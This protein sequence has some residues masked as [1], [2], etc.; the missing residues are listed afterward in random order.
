MKQLP[1]KTPAKL[2]ELLEIPEQNEYVAICYQGTNA[3]WDTGWGLRSFSYFGLYEPMI[4]HLAIAF[5]LDN[6]IDLGS[7]D[8]EPTHVL[9]FEKEG[10][11]FIAE[12]VGIERF[13]KDNN[14]AP[15]PLD[16]AVDLAKWY[17]KIDKNPANFGMFEMFDRPSI[18]F[19]QLA[20]EVIQNL[21]Q[22]VT[23]KMLIEA[24]EMAQSSGRMLFVVNKILTRIQRTIE[25]NN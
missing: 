22:Q 5:Y 21:D 4:N 11:I 2:F 15:P 16:K 9:L 19:Q 3:I 20:I 7:D 25:Q 14:P 24:I 10:F 1:I 13:L 8:T 17:E 23:K 18:E 6:E 12:Y